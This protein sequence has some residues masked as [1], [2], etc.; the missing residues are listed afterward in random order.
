MS[1]IFRFGAYQDVKNEHA[2]FEADKTPVL[3]PERDFT[4]E[5]SA[6]QADDCTERGSGKHGVYYTLNNI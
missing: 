3:I 5:I 1:K 4:S 6:L 2:V